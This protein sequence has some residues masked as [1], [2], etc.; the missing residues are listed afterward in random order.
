MGIALFVALGCLALTYLSIK[1]RVAIWR[2]RNA[3]A[4]DKHAIA[5][6]HLF[7]D[8][9]GFTLSRQAR[10]NHDAIE[11]IYGEI[12][13][14]TF[15]ALLSLTNPD[16]E[17]VFYDLGSGVG[18]AVLAC[19][20]VFTVKKSCGIELFSELHQCALRQQQRLQQLP[21]YSAA[22]DNIHFINANFLQVDFSD[23]THIFINATAFIGETWGA[24]NQR[25][26]AMTTA[27][28][29]ITTTKKLS[30]ASFFVIKTVMVQMSWGVVTAY[31]QRPI[32]SNENIQATTSA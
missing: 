2:W 3:L 16:K 30:S 1:R 23:A 19:A 12:D 6:Q 26:D 21:A 4:L 28:T 13:F 17:T 32:T 8:I 24:L 14:T 9:D 15:I 31:I 25:L 27:T 7:A 22:V 11:Y 10:T 29:V 5:F 18:K 20:M